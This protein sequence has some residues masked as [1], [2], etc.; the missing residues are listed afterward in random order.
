ML[1]YILKFHHYTLREY[2]IIRYI[3]N[4]LAQRMKTIKLQCAKFVMC[5][6]S[7][8]PFHDSSVATIKMPKG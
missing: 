4:I 3:Y 7:G 1:F 6:T 2:N 8:L 5:K